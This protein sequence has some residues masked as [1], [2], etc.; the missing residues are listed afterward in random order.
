[1][2]KIRRKGEVTDFMY[3]KTDEDLKDLEARLS[4]LYAK[5]SKGV[6][7]KL[8]KFLEQF[9]KNDEEKRLMVSQGTMSQKAYTD[10]RMR[11]MFTSNKMKAQIDAL[12]ED[13]VHTDKLAMQMVNGELPNIYTS[14]YNFQGYMAE[15]IAKTAG[16]NYST[17]TL[18]NADAIAYL[19]KDNPNLLP[20]PRVDIPKDMR[21]NRQHISSAIAQGILQGDDI[22][23]IAKRLQTV[24]DMDMNAAIRNAR[25]ATIGAQ[26]KG[27]KDAINRINKDGVIEMIQTW[28][29]A[30]DARTRD[31]HLM[32]DGTEPNEDGL[33]GEGIINTLLQY[34]A[35]PNGDPEEVYN[36]RCRLMATAKEIDHTK[37]KELYEQFM[38]EENYADWS[39][40][41]RREADHDSNAHMKTLEKDYV[42]EKQ[43]ALKEALKKKNADIEKAIKKMR[44]K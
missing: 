21:W 18:Y 28:S 26:N 16:Y 1:M 35:D 9:S 40:Q 24:S 4:S 42:R 25:T 19:T 23:S 37:D 31:T 30:L 43:Q 6:E 5:S 22:P 44:K 20:E 13:M 12:T 7:A 2:A 41:K 29:C 8:D 11:Q 32:M 14:N 39:E 15:S 36:C 27:R 17:F 3:R 10:W 33:F 34:P 38:K